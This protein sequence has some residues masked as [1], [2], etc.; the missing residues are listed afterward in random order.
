[1]NPPE[2]CVGKWINDK[3]EYNNDALRLSTLRLLRSEYLQIHLQA[4]EDLE[5]LKKDALAKDNSLC[6]ICREE[7]V[8]TLLLECAH[9]VLCEKCANKLFAN[10][11]PKCP[12][13]SAKVGRLVRTF[14]S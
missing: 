11:T 12:K 7:A 6:M 5:V 13:C 10:P 8:N 14:H 2:L 9:L 4:H 3:L 1:M